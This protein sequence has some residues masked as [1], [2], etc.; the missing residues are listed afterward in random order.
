MPWVVDDTAGCGS[1]SGSL[2][3]GE[4]TSPNFPAEVATN[5]AWTGTIDVHNTGTEADTFRV[6]ERENT[7]PEFEVAPDGTHTYTTSG[8]GPADFMIYLDRAGEGAFDIWDWIK[9]HKLE[10]AAGSTAFMVLGV[11]AVAR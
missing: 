2:G 8:T 7:S 3:S 4:L 5:E 9:A 11:V 1:C 10:V 6:R